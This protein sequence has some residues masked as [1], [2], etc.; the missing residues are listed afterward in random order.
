MQR[1]QEQEREAPHLSSFSSSSFSCY[2]PFLHPPLL[3]RRCLQVSQELEWVRKALQ[4]RRQVQELHRP[5]SQQLVLF[6]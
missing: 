3:L 6:S 4:R 2:R 1:E 5:S